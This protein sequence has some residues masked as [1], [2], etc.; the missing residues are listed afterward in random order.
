M[1]VMNVETS[2]LVITLAATGIVLSVR[3]TNEKIG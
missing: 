2:P 1:G 3:V